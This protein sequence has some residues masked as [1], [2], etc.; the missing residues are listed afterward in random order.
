MGESR[1]HGHLVA[2]IVSWIQETCR[3]APGI[4][5]VDSGSIE[6]GSRPPA[7]GGYIPDVYVSKPSDTG[8][9]VGE[10][11][12]ARDLERPHSQAQFM[13]FL[14]WCACHDGSLLV[15]AVPWYMT[16]AARNLIAH[17]QRRTHTDGV[18][19]AVLDRIAG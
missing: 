10:A 4:V 7:L 2:A 14:T 11:K 18:N 3:P 19:V 5:L 17:L 6:G 12:T 1:I 13:A 15:V 16:R 8:F 9:L